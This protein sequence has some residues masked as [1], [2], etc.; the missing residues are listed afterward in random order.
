MNKSA[1]EHYAERIMVLINRRNQIRVSEVA[2]WL[3]LNKD[4]VRRLLDW[5]VSEGYINK[6]TIKFAGNANMNVY[7]R[8]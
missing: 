5:M 8:K 3:Y 4:R 7:T 6:K 2:S 1:K